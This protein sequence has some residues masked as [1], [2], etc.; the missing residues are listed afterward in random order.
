MDIVKIAY[1]NG[2]VE[3]RRAH[4]AL[5]ENKKTE[6]EFWAFVHAQDGGRKGTVFMPV[7]GKAEPCPERTQLYP[8]EVEPVCEMCGTRLKV[9]DLGSN[10]ETPLVHPNRG[11]LKAPSNFLLRQTKAGKHELVPTDREDGRTLILLRPNGADVRTG[12][13]VKQV[14]EG[15]TANG[16]SAPVLIA[17]KPTAFIFGPEE[18]PQAAVVC[19]SDGKWRIAT[20]PEAD[21]ASEFEP[22]AAAG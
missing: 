12:P 11:L 10:H 3:V 5:V 18:N 14:D 2:K 9:M 17:K 13:G 21:E 16:D 7:N 19:T 15:T 8:P 20:P 1:K 22:I 6:T 4:P